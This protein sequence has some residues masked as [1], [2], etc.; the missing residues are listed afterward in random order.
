MRAAAVALALPAALASPSPLPWSCTAGSATVNVP[1][2]LS[3]YTVTINNQQ[4]SPLFNL[5]GGDLGLHVGGTPGTYLRASQGTL[6]P[7]SVVATA[8]TDP[9]LGP[10]SALVVEW[11]GSPFPLTTSIL[12]FPAA[13]LVEF[14]ATYPNGTMGADVH[15]W[16]PSEKPSTSFDNFNISM[17]PSLQWPSFSADPGA[18]R[19]GADLSWIEWA[20][21]FSWHLNGWGQ[22]ITNS[23]PGSGSGTGYTGGQLGGPLVLHESSWAA[24]TKPVAAVLAPLDNFKSSI[25]SLQASSQTGQC[26][27]FGPHGHF[28]S[29]PAG[30]T[31]RL[32]LVAPAAAAAAAAAPS[33]LP[34]ANDTGVTAAVYAYGAVLRALHNTTRF[35]PE[36]DI[37]VSMLSLWTDNG[38]VVD[39]DFFGQAGT[40]GTGGQLFAN[41]SAV[42]AATGVPVSSLQL[43]PYWFTRDSPG[44]GN[45]SPSVSVFGEGGFE[46]ATAIFPTTLYSFFWADPSSPYNSFPQFEWVSGWADTF[47]KAVL[48]RVSAQ[49]SHAFYSLLLDRCVSWRC[50]GFEIDFLD[51]TYLGF[52]DGLETVGVYETFMGGMSAAAVEHAVPVQLC[53]P[54]PSDVLLSVQ[55]PGVSNIRASDDDD[56]TYAGDA[57]WKI[58]LT[59]LLHGS[60]NIRPFA[61]NMWTHPMYTGADAVD[62]PYPPFYAQN[63][64]ELGIAVSAL[65]TGPVGLGDKLGFTNATLAL[66]SCATNGVLLKPSLPAAPVDTYWRTPAGGGPPPLQESGGELWQAPSFV[67]VS[68]LQSEDWDG[69]GGGGS[70]DPPSHWL[71]P[72]GLHRFT[73]AAQGTRE[74]DVTGGLRDTF[75]TVTPCPFLSLLA[76]DVPAS[77][78]LVVSPGDLTPSIAW[79]SSACAASGL[80][81]D[82]VGVPWSLGVA[83]LDTLCADGADASGCVIPFPTANESWAGLGIATGVAPTAGLK[84]GEHFFDILSLSPVTPSGYALLGELRKFVRVAPVRFGAVASSESGASTP[85]F[86]MLVAGAGGEAVDV[87]L[88]VPGGVIRRI[89]V[90]FGPAGGSAQVTCQG[91][92]AGATCTV[93]QAVA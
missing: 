71:H 78:G 86:A 47:I 9:V 69:G 6:T 17:S 40:E 3:S 30:H 84:G 10:G 80:A 54:L 64:T 34:F 28:S 50:I 19:L 12:C 39:G 24:G 75:P 42:F 1:P 59:S 68:L 7:S 37:G 76:V 52:A 35:T 66:M 81:T 85:T 49:D 13:S 79:P 67:P 43:D 2:T 55:L 14:R 65:S 56:L 21:E 88:L 58:G 27:V 51:F 89:S 11:A 23:G 90:P 53:M 26:L 83:A 33:L 44:N 62:V 93:K 15:T 82:Y 57:R 18:T 36:A 45:W 4:S 70:V 41:Y 16:D 74:A 31:T 72:A 8:T 63:A 20:G 25:L 32:G 29:L 48:G 92:G 91:S 46:R 60:L 22:G 61:D 38:A 73:L 5:T 87:A 77:A